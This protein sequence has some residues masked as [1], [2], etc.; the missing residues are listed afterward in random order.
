MEGQSGRYK[1]RFNGLRGELNVKEGKIRW[2]GNA[3]A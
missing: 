1:L 3:D 2:Y